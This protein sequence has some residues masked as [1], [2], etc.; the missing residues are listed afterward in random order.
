MNQTLFITSNLVITFGYVFLAAV[1]MPRAT[2][3]LKRTRWGGIVF[4]VTCGLTHLEMIYHY[5]FAASEPVRDVY[6]ELHMLLIHIPQA[7]A[8]WAFVTGLYLELVRWGPWGLDAAQADE[9]AR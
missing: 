6:S 3:R 1:V 8:V 7:I 4:F 2:V 5:A 9:Q